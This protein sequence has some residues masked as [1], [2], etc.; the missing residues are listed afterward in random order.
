MNFEFEISR[1]DCISN[2]SFLLNCKKLAVLVFQKCE[3]VD[4]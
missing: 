3:S 1:V 2:R 4:S